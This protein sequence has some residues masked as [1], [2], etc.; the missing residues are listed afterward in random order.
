MHKVGAL[1]LALLAQ[2]GCKAAQGAAEDIVNA[3]LAQSD[4][5]R[6]LATDDRYGRL[7]VNLPHVPFWLGEGEAFVYRRTTQG[8]HQ[9]MLVDAGRGVKQRL[10]IKLASRQR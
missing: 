7:T 2:Q 3:P 6:A 5:E 4:Y 9:F 8:K 1:I 10:L